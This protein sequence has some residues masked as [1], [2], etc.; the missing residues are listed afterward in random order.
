MIPIADCSFFST[1][2]GSA[3]A[4]LGLS[5]FALIFFLTD[6]FKRY[7]GLTL[8]VHQD[9][10]KSRIKSFDGFKIKSPENISDYELFDGDPLVVFSAFSVGLTWNMYF[11]ALVLSLTAVSGNLA[12]IWVFTIEICSFWCFVTF[13]LITRNTKRDQLATYRTR[14]EHFWTILEWAFV[15]LWGIGALLT[16]VV[17]MDIHYLN[18]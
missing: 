16:F 8:P 12:N 5:F 6:I 1:V 14:D 13:S 17:A 2:A 3:A 18:N 4:L 7:Q 9:M 15:A 10:L 11:I